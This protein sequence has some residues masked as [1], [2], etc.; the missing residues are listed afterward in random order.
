M[1]AIAFE[2]HRG[3]FRWSLSAAVVVVVH[4]A[5]GLAAVR[6]IDA[7]PEPPPALAAVVIDL[8]PL[9]APPAPPVDVAPGPQQ[10]ETEPARPR[11][12]PQPLPVEPPPID[13]LRPEPAKLPEPPQPPE[14]E[15]IVTQRPA[16]Q[17]LPEIPPEPVEPPPVEPV[18]QVAVRMPPE[19][20]PPPGPLPEPEPEVALPP[21]PDVPPP[22][23]PPEVAEV[24]PPPE[25]VP[26]PVFV[27]QASVPT[28]TAPPE[29]QAP[30]AVTAAAPVMADAS[31]IMASV[32]PSFEQILLAHLEQH[33]RYPA[34]ARKRHQ[35]GT[36]TLRFV[37]DREGHVLSFRLER[38]SGYDLLDDEVLEMIRRAEPLPAIP[39]E[40]GRDRLELVV[41]V[42]FVLK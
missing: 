27:P 4:L 26:E 30:E 19:R 14:P 39:A 33:R 15:P 1:S 20:I 16:P 41:P 11:L 36:A 28:T 34:R 23:P 42:R 9:A 5:A 31:A 8:A 10:I 24:E 22:P 25:P 18:V 3:G 13:S 37:M 38:S 40:L 35:E 29:V 7:P 12:R 32:M 21:V 2:E 17:L 6:W